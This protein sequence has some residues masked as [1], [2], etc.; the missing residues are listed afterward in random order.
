MNLPCA[1]S[2]VPASFGVVFP[3]ITET[4]SVAAVQLP[5]LIPGAVPTLS[6]ITPHAWITQTPRITYG[7][8]QLHQGALQ[9]PLSLISSNDSG[10][11]L[12][13][14]PPSTSVVLQTEPESTCDASRGRTATAMCISQW[15]EL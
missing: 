4:T 6:G 3:G 11:G 9:N 8:A 15:R 2:L 1:V 14:E 12:P 7:S 10:T 13:H 5:A